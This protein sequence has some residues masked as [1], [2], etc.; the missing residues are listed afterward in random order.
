MTE[1]NLLTP[2]R[3]LLDLGAY[4]FYGYGTDLCATILTKTFLFFS[5]TIA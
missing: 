3:L 1:F 2:Q 5:V 4:D